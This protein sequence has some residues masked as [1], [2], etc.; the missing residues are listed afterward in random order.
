MVHG[1]ATNSS[2]YA[3]PE[4][5]GILVEL[6]DRQG[7]RSEMPIE[8]WLHS[9]PPPRSTLRPV[10]VRLESSGGRLPL[11]CIVPLRYRNTPVSRLLIALRLV[12]DP[13]KLKKRSPVQRA[14]RTETL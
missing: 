9:G 8:G 10:A 12:A 2:A 7:S 5:S 4:G 3:G 6:R 13:W 11:P 1:V 14:P